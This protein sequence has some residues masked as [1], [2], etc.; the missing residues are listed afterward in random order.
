MAARLHERPPHF[1]E[2]VL[3]GGRAA[4]KERELE[5]AKEIM[6]LTSDRQERLRLWVERTGKSEPALYRRLIE[7]KKT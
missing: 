3:S 5:I 4:R 2:E 6:A 7:L 1:R